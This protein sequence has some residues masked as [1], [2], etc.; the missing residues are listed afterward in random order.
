MSEFVGRTGSHRVYSYPEARRGGGVLSLARNFAYG[1]AET[2]TRITTDGTDVPWGLIESG[3]APGVLVPITPRLSGIVRVSGVITIVNNDDARQ[4][5]QLQVGASNGVDPPTFFPPTQELNSIAEDLGEEPGHEA[6]P[7]TAL[8]TGA[9]V[10]I[11]FY[12]LIRL[13]ANEND[14][15]SLL[16]NSSTIDLQEVPPA[17]G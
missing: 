12:I 14:A 8:V 16:V 4:D 9:D 5:V 1:P 15:L 17:T 13:T 7:F 6:I 11:L 10:G 2:E 3:E